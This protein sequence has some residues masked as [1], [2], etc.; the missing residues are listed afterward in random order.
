MRSI[1]S[2]PGILLI[3]GGAALLAAQEPLY[4]F[5]TTVYGEPV[6]TF[7][8]TVDSNS[9]FRGTIYYLEAGARKLPDFSTLDPVGTIYTKYLCVPPRAFDEGFP[10]VT[11]RFEWFAI[12]YWGRFWIANPGRYRF[13]LQSDDGSILYVDGKKV[14]LNDHQHPPMEKFGKVTLKTGPH[15]IRVSY[16][17]GPRFHVALVLRVAG[18]GDHEFHVFHTDEFKPPAGAGW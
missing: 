16:Y 7:G 10:G 9:G 1:R 11:D 12:D 2:A 13:A 14:I 8:T 18:P 6:Y 4:K 3:L 17:Q 5:S 15:D